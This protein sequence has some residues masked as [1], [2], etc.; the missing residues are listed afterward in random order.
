VR[1]GLR[2][3]C[4]GEQVVHEGDLLPGAARVERIERTGVVL[5]TEAGPVQLE[6]ATTR[7]GPR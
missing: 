2:L 7:A 6:T 5:A 4:F 3:A 1:G